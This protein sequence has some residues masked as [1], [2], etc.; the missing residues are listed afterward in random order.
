MFDGCITKKQ[1][2]EK[3]CGMIKRVLDVLFLKK[4]F[5]FISLPDL[6][7]NVACSY[8]L[9][10]TDCKYMIRKNIRNRHFRFLYGTLYDYDVFFLGRCN[11]F[12]FFLASD[13][14]LI[15]KKLQKVN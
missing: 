13:R 14:D 4:G 8:D 6:A 1:V 3:E 2:P 15:T 9:D 5:E 11:V 7:F 10:F 12:V